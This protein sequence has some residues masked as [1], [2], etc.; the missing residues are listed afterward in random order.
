VQDHAQ[1]LE[2]KAPEE[3]DAEDNQ[4]SN[5]DDLNETHCDFPSERN[6]LTEGAILVALV[7]HVNT[8]W[9]A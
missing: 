6:L 7:W 1:G 4:D 5:N 8:L 9:V 3:Q 2:K